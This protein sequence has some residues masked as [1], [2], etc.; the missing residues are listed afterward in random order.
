MKLLGDYFIDALKGSTFPL[1]DA[2]TVRPS[3]TGEAP[4]YPMLII[5]EAPGIGAYAGNQPRIGRNIITLEAYA[6][7]GMASGQ[8]IS[9]KDAAFLLLTE[10]D[11]ILNEKYGLTISGQA[12][13]APYTDETVFRAVA[14]Y[15]VS[16]DLQ[17]MVF[18]RHS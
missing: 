7:D 15:V 13:G 5:D 18:Y 1:D 10:A 11:R 2:V 4:K 9:K 16:V 8:L 14:R 12:H 6:Q 17:T 3:Y